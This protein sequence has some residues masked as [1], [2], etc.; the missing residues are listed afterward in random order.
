[1][2]DLAVM[3]ITSLFLLLYTNCEALFLTFQPPYQSNFSQQALCVFST[4]N[5]SFFSV[6][7]GLHNWILDNI[8]WD[9]TDVTAVAP[10]WLNNSRVMCVSSEL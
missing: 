9:T 8:A 2:S 5:E 4:N 10:D 7:S 6:C 3:M 1:M